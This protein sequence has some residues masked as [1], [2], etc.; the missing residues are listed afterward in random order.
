MKSN[1][2][3]ELEM[4]ELIVVPQANDLDYFMLK[5]FNL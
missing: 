5:C 4:E 1:S 2:C 3:N